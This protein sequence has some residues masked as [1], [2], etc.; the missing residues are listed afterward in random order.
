VLRIEES[1]SST[2]GLGVVVVPMKLTIGVLIAALLDRVIA[3][4][5]MD[6]S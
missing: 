6:I 2:A 5:S 1:E 3:A 4:H